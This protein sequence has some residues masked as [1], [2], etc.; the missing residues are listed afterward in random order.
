MNVSRYYIHLKHKVANKN[1]ADHS[2]TWNMFTTDFR[3][4]LNFMNVSL[5]ELYF[6]NYRMLMQ[7]GSLI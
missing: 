4:N 5:I 3:V 7:N 6:I 2:S 1:I